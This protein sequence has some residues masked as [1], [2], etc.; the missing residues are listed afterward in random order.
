MPAELYR[1]S[2]A[3]FNPVYINTSAGPSNFNPISSINGPT[4]VFWAPEFTFAISDAETYLL[5]RRFVMKLRGG[6]VLARLFDPTMTAEIFGDQ[7]RGSGGATPTVNIALDAEAGAETIT[8]KN[9]VASQ[10]T[11]FMSG[12]MLGIGENLYVVED[13]CGSDAGGEATVS[14]QPPLRLGVAEDDPVNTL[15]PTGLFRLISGAQDLAMNLDRMGQAF[16]LVFQEVPD[17][18]A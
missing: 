18:D 11:A 10:A 15:A 4:A 14:I 17:T 16:T 9:L 5:Y 6:K 2:S 7:P 8:I 13:D 1:T 12:D 3:K